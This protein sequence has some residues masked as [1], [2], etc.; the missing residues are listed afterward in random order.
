MRRLKRA[1]RR[2]AA[3]VVAAVG[4]VAGPA[5]A[6]ASDLSD[7]ELAQL[8]SGAL[9]VRPAALV[10]GG[11]RY[12]G[13]TSWVWV[14]A[15]PERV[16]ATLDDVGSYVG[17]LPKARQVRLVGIT[18][19][20]DSVVTVEQGTSVAHARYAA[21]VHREAL[22]DE[23]VV[24]RFQLDPTLEHDLSDAR[25]AFR[26]EPSGSGTLLEVDVML[27]LGPGIVRWLFEDKVRD[28]AL[29]VPDHVRRWVEAEGRVAAAASAPDDG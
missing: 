12:V 1:A 28:L 4:L 13:G 22:G 20:G 21:R 6:G 15:P 29:S 5:G 10:E 7:A 24:Y 17:F 27:D 11:H 18:R 16:V 2:V 9:L 14:D 25:G 8:R 26:V 19:D 23:R 3:P